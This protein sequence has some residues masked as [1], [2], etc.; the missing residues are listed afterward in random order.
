MPGCRTWPDSYSQ[1]QK[2]GVLTQK[3]HIL[4]I[5]FTALNWTRKIEFRNFIKRNRIKTSRAI[6]LFLTGLKNEAK[7]TKESSFIIGKYLVTQQITKTEERALKKQVADLFKIVGI[8]I[9][10]ILIPGATILIPFIIRVADKKGIDIIPS[11][12][13]ISEKDKDFNQPL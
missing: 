1:Y 6:V 3:K 9:P 8:G 12:F 7:D 4:G 10:F 5:D 2:T 13:K 11:N